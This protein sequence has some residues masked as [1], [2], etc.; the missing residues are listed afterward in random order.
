MV[1]KILR[2][3][4]LAE[5]GLEAILMYCK[6]D[7]FSFNSSEQKIF[8]ESEIY[9]PLP[10]RGLHLPLD[11]LQLLSRGLTLQLFSFY[12]TRNIEAANLLQKCIEES[13][14]NLLG[15]KDILLGFKEMSCTKIWIE[16]FCQNHAYTFWTVEFG[17]TR[18]FH[19]IP[20]K[21]KFIRSITTIYT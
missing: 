17:Q 5:I 8:C 12:Q 7:S 1:W 18:I 2:S 3:I 16:L 10:I 6:A 19:L 4:S 11:L 14:T 20:V 9:W 15:I 21:C 13:H